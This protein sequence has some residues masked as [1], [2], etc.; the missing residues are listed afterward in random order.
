M[1]VVVFDGL[2]KCMVKNDCKWIKATKRTQEKARKYVVD[3]DTYEIQIF[4]FLHETSVCVFLRFCVY[5]WLVGCVCVCIEV[6]GFWG[7]LSFVCLV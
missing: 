1:C 5:V 2:C 7:V 6:C 3:M 4:Q